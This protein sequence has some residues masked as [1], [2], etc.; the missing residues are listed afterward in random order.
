MIRVPVSYGMPL[1]DQDMLVFMNRWLKLKEKDG[2]REDLFARVPGAKTVRP[3]RLPTSSGVVITSG[4][5]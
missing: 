1:G 2:T 5:G 4:V 3:Q